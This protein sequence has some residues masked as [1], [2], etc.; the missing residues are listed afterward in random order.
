MPA[1]ARSNT[2]ALRVRAGARALALVAL[3]LAEPGMADGLKITGIQA[4][5]G[6]ER[7]LLRGNIDVALTP[8]VEEALN[9]G[10]PLDFVLEV[11]LHRRRALIWDETTRSWSARRELR[12]HALSGQYLVT[13]SGAQPAPARASF[14]SLA[15]ALTAAGVLDES[16]A[17]E[18]PLADGDGDYRVGVRVHLDIEALPPVLR[19]VAYTSRAWDLNSGWTMWKLEH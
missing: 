13:R 5:L 1:H 18:P 2:R 14:Q 3:T 19:P 4:R 12:Y 16:L 10:I 6:P 8:K 11:R 17:L 9:N 7:L 15:E